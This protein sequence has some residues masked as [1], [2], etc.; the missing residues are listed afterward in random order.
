MPCSPEGSSENHGKLQELQD[1][2]DRLQ[3]DVKARKLF[4]EDE[5]E[6]DEMSG[7]GEEDFTTR[8]RI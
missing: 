5:D 6:M 3:D 1:E 8:D 2:M 4:E 7:E